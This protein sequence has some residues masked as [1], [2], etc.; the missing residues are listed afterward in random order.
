MDSSFLTWINVGLAF[1]SVIL[2]LKM[3]IQFGLPNHPARVTTYL[4]SLCVSSF[5]VMKAAAGLGFLSPLDWMNWRTLPLVTGGLAILFQTIMVIGSFS[6]I[7]QK[8]ISRLPLMAGLLCLAFFRDRADVF[9]AFSLGAAGLCLTISR[10]KARYQKRLF[11]KM[12][13][14]LSLFAVLALAQEYWVFLVGEGFLFFALFYFFLFEQSFALQA[15][16]DDRASNL[17]GQKS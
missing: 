1:Y 10:G 12:I 15:L 8:V 2:L 13:F 9:M 16:I 4:V 5:F 7:Q 14:F 17:E 11:F 6:L 3:M